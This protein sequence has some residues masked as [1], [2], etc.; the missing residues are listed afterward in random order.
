MFKILLNAIFLFG[1]V[2]SYVPAGIYIDNGYDQTSIDRALTKQE[3]RDMELEILHMLGLP[4]RPRRG[5]NN[6]PL[7]K[8]ASKFMMDVYKNILDKENYEDHHERR[9]RSVDL[10]LS[11]EEEKAID[12]SDVIMTFENSNRRIS[13]VRHERGKRLWF[14]VSTVPLDNTIL[15]AE[16][17]IFQTPNFNANI[18]NSETIY[19]VT[20]YQLA[21]SSEGERELE[22][23]GT[24]NVTAGYSGWV[25]INVTQSLSTWV[26]LPQSNKGFYLS[27]HPHDKP[28]HDVRPEDIG[29]TI[30]KAEE[31]SQPFMV[32][33]FKSSK[34]INV[35]PT[36]SIKKV[37]TIEYRSI[38][39]RAAQNFDTTSDG[40]NCK[41]RTL[42]VS[43]ET[44]KWKDWI[45]AP[46]GYAA[47]YCDGDCK[48]P[49]NSHMN[50]TNHAIVQTLAHLTNPVK[51]PKPCCA[52]TKLTPISVLYYTDLTNVTLKRYKNMVVK[53]C[54]CH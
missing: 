36:R 33:F 43:F 44:L 23:V 22:F 13:G 3:K 21:K 12:E 34:P 2:S 17:R 18:T 15:G 49:L 30:S 48:F 53:S 52:P 42:Y 24:V 25:A 31:E 16:L 7:T 47:H 51:Y 1:Y 19:A 27:V 6:T 39:K 45:I 9:E 54:G 28:G 38:M 50:A 10:N 32:A 26:A 40:R 14:N 41:I 37:D 46:V 20:A 8:S 35:R 5:A 11:G 4:N 29:L